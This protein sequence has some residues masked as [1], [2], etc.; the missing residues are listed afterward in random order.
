MTMVPPTNPGSTGFDGYKASSQSPLPD[1]AYG[2]GVTYSRARTAVILGLLGI[3]PFSILTG[4]PAIY[5]GIRALKDI[6]A[7][8]G[9]LKGRGA[10]WCAIVLG[11][12]SVLVFAAVIARV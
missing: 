8:G 9:A 7:S 10:A 12:V 6:K 11:V 5:V 4:I 1:G 2:N 3:V